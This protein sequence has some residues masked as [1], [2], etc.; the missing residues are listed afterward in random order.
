VIVDAADLG[1]PAALPAG[2]RLVHI[3]PSKTGTTSLQGAMWVAR[4]EMRAQGV[5]YAGYNRHS[6]GAARAAAGMRSST[7]DVPVAGQLWAGLVR[8]VRRARE[9]RVVISSEFLAHAS[10]EAVRR[11]ID[12]LDPGRVHVVVT[13]RPLARM[14]ASLW[15]QQ[16]QSGSSRPYEAWLDRVLGRSGPLP[17]VP[18]WHRHRHDRLIRRWADVVGPGRLTAI[19]LDGGDHDFVTRAFE[20]LLGLRPGTIAMQ[21]DY[22]NRSLTLGEVEA[23]RAFNAMAHRDGMDAGATVRFLHNGTRAMKLRT[24]DRDEQRI[25]TPA[26][27]VERAAGIAAEV[28]AGIA[29]SGVSVIG[30]LEHLLEVPPAATSAVSPA[31]AGMAPAAAAAMTTGIAYAS[32]LAPRGRKAG[33]G[34]PLVLAEIR[35][36]DYLR[37]RDIARAIGRRVRFD[38]SRA[39]RALLGLGA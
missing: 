6:T 8:E 30:N 32:G 5:R 19:V 29:A 15:Q 33:D 36:L 11:I 21:P 22:A 9:D 12:D 3:G 38:V 2:T 24:P 34:R 13:L 4:H 16:V 17:D 20:G 23:I 37:Y 10:D 28:V 39:V 27:A 1:G 26:W 25:E 31:T 7:T 18:L 14:L 35:D